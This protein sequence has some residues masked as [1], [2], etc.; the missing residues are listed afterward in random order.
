MYKSMSDFL[1]SEKRGGLLLV[2]P[3]T[4]SGKTYCACQV[5]FDYVH[6]Q[7]QPK[8]IYFTTT[9]L[10]NLPENEL[11][12]AYENNK[13]PNFKNEVLFIKSNE[14]FVKDNLPNVNV[15][16]KYQT[17]EYLKIKKWIETVGSE[18]SLKSSQF[19]KDEIKKQL[20]DAEVQFRKF[21]HKIIEKEIKG[22]AEQKKIAIRNDKRYKWIGEI[23]PTVFMDDYKIYLLSVNKLLVRNDTLIKKSYPFISA[24]NLKDAVIFIDEFDAT[25][26]TIKES[27][28]KEAVDSSN[29][30]LDIFKELHSKL[31]Y[32]K[33]SREF[34]EPYKK[35]AENKQGQQTLESLEAEADSLYEK[36][37]LAYNY[38]L[39]SEDYDKKRGFLFFDGSFRSYLENNRHYIRTVIDDEERKG[40]IFFETKDEYEQKKHIETDINIYSLLRDVKKFLDDFVRFIM[41]WAEIY[42]ESENS[43]RQGRSENPVLFTFEN[44]IN[45]IFDNY[46]KNEKLN[47]IFSKFVKSEKLRNVRKSDS[48]IDDISFYGRGFRFFEFIDGEDHNEETKINFVQLDDTPEKMLLFIAKNCKVIGLSATAKIDSVLSNY[49][50]KYLKD[51]LGDSFSELSEE[52]YSKL[53]KENE[54]KQASYEKYSINVNVESVDSGK[55][56]KSIKER[57]ELS[58][59]DKDV[60]KNF[61][62]KLDNLSL[63]DSSKEYYKKRYCNIFDV[64]KLF[65]ENDDIKSFLCLN[66]ALPK[67]NEPKLDIGIFKMF[68]DQYCKVHDKNSPEIK[69]LR[70]EDFDDKKN[71]IL[72]GLSNGKKIF[73]FSTYKTVGAGQNLQYEIPK[74]EDTISLFSRNSKDDNKKDFDAIYLG[75]VTNVVTNI[76]DVKNIGK[77]ELLEFL[78]EIKYLYENNEISPDD[79]QSFVQTGF[80][81]YSGIPDYYVCSDKIRN[82]T[83]SR[84]K[85]TRDVVQAVG[86]LCRTSNKKRNIYIYTNNSLLSSLDTNCVDKKLVNYELK[87]LFEFAECYEAELP[88]EKIAI[89]NEACRKSEYANSY[90]KSMLQRD[91]TEISIR[92]WKELRECVLRYP[93]APKVLEEKNSVIRKFYIQNYEGKSIYHYAQRGDFS[94]IKINLFNDFTVFKK[95]LESDYGNPIAVSENSSRLQN[96][97][98]YAGLKDYFLGQGFAVGFGDGDLILCPVLFN[99][100]YKGALGE[101]C[102]KFILEKE[103]NT[104]LKKITNPDYFEFF[105]YEL[106]DGIYIDFK[107]WKRA[108]VPNE[109][110]IR[111]KIRSKLNSMGGKKAYIINIIKESDFVPTI[112]NE[113]VEIPYLI[114][115]N[116]A[117]NKDAI[118]MLIGDVYNVK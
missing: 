70:S 79:L 71:A 48:V 72:E 78:F 61:L 69:I 51:E 9:L 57:L 58:I 35:Y 65:I 64:L 52:D 68:S 33:P 104:Q 4:G 41:K 15:P 45:T 115:E 32:Y 103:L 98:A 6:N 5:I 37:S 116:G 50:L 38:K 3:N 34:Y 111:E 28:I 63:P 7:K 74:S 21:L 24:E 77:K 49:S 73:V 18:S 44:A 42:A 85:I 84:R 12:A 99:N 110:S 55:E 95:N 102:G 30:Y 112:T 31:H 43:K 82:S 100:I 97:F 83:S 11:K 60:T 53:V 106:S 109:N 2:D 113:Y 36:Y 16:E 39:F 46:L 22:T 13:N 114:D 80:K 17:D 107:H 101:V 67:E 25:K 56:N 94:D 54:E 75:D 40:K 86:R 91:W 90:I 8:K 10:K 66:M 105:D 81:A 108:V 89:E 20:R 118:K 1:Q 23:Y 117:P 87:K 27:L 88:D 96:M 93:T 76:C 59:C 92:L 47:S 19:V 29:D 14:D 62:N 26:E